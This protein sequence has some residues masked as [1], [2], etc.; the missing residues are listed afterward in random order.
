MVEANAEVKTDE[1]TPSEAEQLLITKH[2]GDH[3]IVDKKYKATVV[4]SREQ[5]DKRRSLIREIE[6]DFQLALQKGDYYLGN[7][8]INFYLKEA[9]SNDE[10]LFINSQAL[11]VADL[12]INDREMAD[13]PESF[14]NQVIP[15]RCADVVQGWNTVQLRYLTPYNKNRVGL[16]T[17]TDSADQQ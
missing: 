16:H 15:L 1:Y 3:A 12:R 10:D 9:P 2:L 4:L 6:Y 14:Q 13:G 5:A 7:A 8:V 11:A 17:F